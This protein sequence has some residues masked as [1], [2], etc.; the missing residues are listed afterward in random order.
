MM[1]PHLAMAGGGEFDLIRR[2]LER[3]GPLASGI[4][5]DV[6]VLDLPPGERLVVS[7]DTAVE[8]V[9]FRS[10]WLTPREIGAR[11]TAAALS[12]LAAAAATPRGVV[13][14]L[15]LTEAS[16]ECIEDI[17]EGIADAVATA[18]PAARIIGG[19][20]TRS[21]QLSI[22]ITA[23][24]SAVAPLSRS[25]A[26]P[27][28]QVYVSGVLGG[29]AEALRAW[30]AGEAPLPWARSRFAAPRARIAEAL[31]LRERGAVAAIDISDGLASELRHLAVA[32]GVEVR[33]DV[34]R[35]PCPEGIPWETAASS[36][37]EYELV[38]VT[39]GA[40][41]VD[42]FA[43]TFALPL[44]RIGSVRPAEVPG[45]DARKGGT[46]VDLPRGHDHF[47]R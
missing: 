29:P 13:V 47:S 25:G 15:G 20:I 5:S 40:I 46:R 4:G 9:H 2:M 38:V 32:S 43:R 22:G 39:R 26:Q 3:W 8:G 37:E 30:N 14:A 44:T 33:V 19:D 21:P 23:L 42:A 1:A 12:D 34:G 45:V 18:G 7:T 35:L 31:W 10:A 17:A 6:A 36:G 16:T 27:G 24:G 28:D 41:D 11:A